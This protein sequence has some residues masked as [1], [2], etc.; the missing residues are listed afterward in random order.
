M[1]A[2]PFDFKKEFAEYYLPKVEPAIVVLP[3]FN[4]I[5]IDGQGDPNSSLFAER[6]QTLYSL[7][8]TMKMS[9]KSGNQPHGYYDYITPPLEGLWWT[10]DGSFDFNKR[11]NWK[12]TLMIRQP[13]FFDAAFFEWACLE[14]SK[15][16]PKLEL[17]KIDF[18][19][20][21]EGVCVQAMHKGPYSDEPITIAGIQRFIESNG[22]QDMVG[23]GAKHH[24]IY[25]LGARKGDPASMKTVLRH[26]VKRNPGV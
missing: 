13:E 18:K 20:F 8:F 4:F 16:K 2:K 10:E 24:E 22:C 15:R 1:C 12:W 5:S 25:S 3:S 17:G 6:V 23:L 19:S 21:T 11:D 9:N 14:L 7:S 26:P